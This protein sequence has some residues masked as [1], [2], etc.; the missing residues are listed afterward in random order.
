MVENLCNKLLSVAGVSK[1]ILTLNIAES[2]SIPSC[3]N[4]EIIQNG[5]P[6]GFAENHNLA[7]ELCTTKYF[8]V[9]NPDVDIDPAIFEYLKQSM[10]KVDAKLIA[11][12]VLSNTGELEDSVRRFPTFKNLLMKA[13]GNDISRYPLAPG[14]EYVFPNWIAGMFM[15]FDSEAFAAV[16]GFDKRFFLYYEDVDICARF[17]QKAYRVAVCQK[18]SIIHEAQRDSRKRVR[19]MFW[20]FSSLIRYFYKHLWRLPKTPEYN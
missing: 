17:W 8:L 4:L 6:R 13:L 18:A 9:L 3:D 14:H 16:G 15:L 10:E 5:T 12:L 7:F 20:H 19:Y 2:L 11:P 1:L